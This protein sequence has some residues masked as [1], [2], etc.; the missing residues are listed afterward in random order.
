[1]KQITSYVGAVGYLNKLFD[2][3]NQRFFNS[4]LVRPTITI[5]SS[6]KTYGHF[7]L[8]GDTWK[9]STG[10]SFEI[11]IAAGTLN[12]PIELTAT[13]LYHEMVHLYCATHG[14]K[15]T[16]NHYAYHNATFKREAEAHGGAV[17][18][19]APRAHYGWTVTKPS[20]AMLSF[21]QEHKLT[22]ILIA[23]NEGMVPLA[24]TKTHS[25]KYVCPCCGMSIRATR[26]VNVACLDCDEQLL[27]VG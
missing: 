13:T 21:V 12:R 26:V 4:E 10:D 8:R 6:P 25:R 14:L 9:S 16:S 24:P 23:R 2:L 1:M 3:L 20:E 27:L 7:T 15:D 22:D 18:E 17:V 5:Q 19:R 11:N